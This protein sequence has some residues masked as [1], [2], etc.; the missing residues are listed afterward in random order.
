MLIWLGPRFGWTLASRMIWLTINSIYWPML[1]DCSLN[2][3]PPSNYLL[4]HMCLFCLKR[5]E[6]FPGWSLCSW[7][8]E[9]MFKLP[10]HNR[11]WMS[12]WKI[13][14]WRSQQYQKRFC[15]CLG[16]RNTRWQYSVVPMAWGEAS[17]S[18]PSYFPL[19]AE[20]PCILENLGR[21]S[22]LQREYFCQTNT[23]NG[24]QTLGRKGREDHFLSFMSTW[25]EGIP[26][27]M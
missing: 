25:T 24:C 1:F 11:C 6:N 3:T 13:S 9:N 26:N 15:L 21:F 18:I 22:V 5:W 2:C 27:W 4:V 8:S 23:L 16:S 10:P 19:V 14:Q 12:K 7:R 20:M 17:R